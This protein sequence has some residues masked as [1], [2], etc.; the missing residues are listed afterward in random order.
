[1][2]L[3]KAQKATLVDSAGAAV[4]QRAI[5]ERIAQESSLARAIM[6]GRARFAAYSGHNWTTTPGSVTPGATVSADAGFYVRPGWKFIMTS[7]Q[8][9]ADGECMVQS[10][11]SPDA[12]SDWYAYLLE[13]NVAAMPYNQ[14]FTTVFGSGGGSDTLSFPSGFPL[15]QNSSLLLQYKTGGTTA[16][17]VAYVATGYEVPAT[18]SSPDAKLRIA[19]VG[20]SLSA[21]GNMG[22][23]ADG[24]TYLG[25]WSWAAKLVT[26]A[27]AAGVDCG[28]FANFSEDGRTMLEMGYNLLAGR[29]DLDYDV[30]I[31]A[32]GMN[33]GASA[34]Y[35]TEAKFKEFAQAFI[36]DRDRRFPGE[37]K[38]ILFCAPSNTDDADRTGS[39]RI[40][41][42]RTWISDVATAAGE[43]NGVGYVNWASAWALNA[44]PASD[45]NIKATERSSGARVHHSGIGS[46][47]IGQYMFDQKKTFL[48][49]L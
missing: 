19:I 5:G 25:N 7:L 14:R 34:N 31:V 47:A 4:D 12:E 44:T 26:L 6:S 18:D 15:A 43:G 39:S 49:G 1:M 20:D 24:R 22:T 8:M 17:R 10:V 21:W 27:R 3:L 29:Y 30:L 28:V 9:S 48:F 37:G 11:I 38:K 36:D 16:R 42:V 23:D 40:A 13:A 45:T 46:T 35:P 33:D 32:L 41:N 2:A